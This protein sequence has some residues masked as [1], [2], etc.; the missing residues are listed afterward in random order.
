[1]S[2][3]QAIA[4]IEGVLAAAPVSL[5][6]HPDNGDLTLLESSILDGSFLLIVSD[7]G[8][9]WPEAAPAGDGPRIWVA[10]V[11]IEVGTLIKDSYQ[12]S[13][14]LS[15]NRGRSVVEALR[16]TNLTYGQV[17]PVVEPSSEVAERLILWS[18]EYN[19]RYEE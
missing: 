17:W 12:E 5:T 9:P 7:G 2:L 15:V 4:E 18:A 19:L 1:M 10:T 14:I 8:E 13:S 3:T 16:Y 6:K 11:R